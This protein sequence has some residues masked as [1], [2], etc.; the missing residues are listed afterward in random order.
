MKT[1]IYVD[2]LDDEAFK[3][4][5]TSI[6]SQISDWVKTRK[7]NILFVDS[8]NNIPADILVSRSD[9]DLGVIIDTRKPV[10]LGKVLDYLQDIAK[11]HS[12]DFVIGFFNEES[13]AA[14]DVCYFGYE[15]GRPDIDEVACYLGMN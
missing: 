9:H 15:A 8:E 1:Y 5:K 7:S 11:T 14:E 10:T 12:L 6:A 13:K 2:C 4:S 3:E